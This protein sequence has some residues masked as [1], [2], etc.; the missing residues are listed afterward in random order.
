MPGSEK[1]ILVVDDDK[2][3]LDMYSVKFM[4]EGY[5]VVGCTSGKDALS[6][7]REGATPDALIVDLIMPDIDG[8]DLLRIV[9][10]EHLGGDNMAKIILSNQEQGDDKKKAELLGADGYIVKA[11]AVPTEVLKAVEAICKKKQKQKK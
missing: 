10:D 5:D 8:F 11:L 3:L 9:K 4:Q 6:R 2:F 1:A 7:L